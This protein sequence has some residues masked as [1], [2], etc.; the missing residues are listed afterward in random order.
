[1]NDAA[2]VSFVK[3][4]GYLNAYAGKLDRIKRLA[5]DSRIETLTFD[6]LHGNK[7]C[8]ICLTYLVDVSN[9]RM[10]ECSCGRRFLFESTHP[11]SI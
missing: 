2:C 6:I 10:V 3:R 9:V 11:I 7:V 5:T 4:I 1:M 8:A